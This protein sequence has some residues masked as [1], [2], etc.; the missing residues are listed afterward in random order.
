MFILL[1]ISSLDID[2]DESNL[3]RNVVLK[4]SRRSISVKGGRNYY[5]KAF[6][7]P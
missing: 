3:L 4:L 2:M 1:G 6:T 5:F 7:V